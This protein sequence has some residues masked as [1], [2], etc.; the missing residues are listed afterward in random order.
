MPFG[1]LFVYFLSNLLFLRTEP[2]QT[3][4]NSLIP[5]VADQ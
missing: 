4:S 2:D 5:L 3:W 1:W